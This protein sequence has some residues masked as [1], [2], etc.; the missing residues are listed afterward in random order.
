MRKEYEEY[1]RMKILETRAIERAEQIKAGSGETKEIYTSI[2]TKTNPSDK[3][4]EPTINVLN[5]NEK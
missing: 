5:L 1:K 3:T 2:F 4:Q